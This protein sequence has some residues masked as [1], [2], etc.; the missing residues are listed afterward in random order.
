MD[1]IW[2]LAKKSKNCLVSKL[3]DIV[4]KG[5]GGLTRPLGFREKYTLL[6]ERSDYMIGL[7]LI[8]AVLGIVFIVVSLGAVVL[9]DPIITVLILYGVYRL[10]KHFCKK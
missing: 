4:H 2:F 1:Y 3:N 7:L 10:I 9:I 5:K 8:L 6:Y